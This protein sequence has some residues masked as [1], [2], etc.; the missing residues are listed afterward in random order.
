M[1]TQ[2]DSPVNMQ[3]EDGIHKPKAGLGR[4]HP[5]DSAL[6]D[7]QLR[8]GGHKQLLLEPLSVVLGC[9]SPGM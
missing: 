6:S 1:D 2:R 8:A 7:F 3:G 5:A 9:G 4:R